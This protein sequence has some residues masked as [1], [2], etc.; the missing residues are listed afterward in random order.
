MY[1]RLMSIFKNLF[2][3]RHHQVVKENVLKE[4]FSFE[5]GT[6]ITLILL[7]TIFLYILMPLIGNS[8]AA[9]YG[10]SVTLTL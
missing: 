9:W 3:L 5:R 4:L 8:I 10:I 1:N 7:E 2:E 6:L